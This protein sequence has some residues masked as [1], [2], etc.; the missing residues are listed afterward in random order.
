MSVLAVCCSRTMTRRSRSVGRERRVDRGYRR[1]GSLRPARRARRRDR[2]ER[3]RRW[4]GARE[5]GRPPPGAVPRRARPR[6]LDAGAELS[7][8]PCLVDRRDREGKFRVCSERGDVDAGDVLVATNAYA[9][10]CRG[11]LRRSCSPVGSFVIATEVLDPEIARAV[12]PRGRMFFDTTNLSAIGGC[13]RRRVV[14]GGRTSL[15]ATTVRRHATCCTRGWCACT[16][17]SRGSRSTTHGV[18]TSRS[19]DR[20]PTAVGSTALRMRDGLQRHRQSPSRPGSGRRCRADVGAKSLPP[21][22]AQLPF[23]ASIRSRHQLPPHGRRGSVAESWLRR[24]TLGGSL[25]RPSHLT[26][27]RR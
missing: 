23:P 14:F 24:A 9:D 2:Y 8:Q 25:S 12:S 3:V 22:F 19:R 21:V 15:G 20:L 26:G 18:G 17:S 13:P 1:A 10:G 6:A 11:P 7:E 4:S 16:H 5:D 27:S